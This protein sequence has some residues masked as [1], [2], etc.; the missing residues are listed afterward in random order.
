MS[1][2]FLLATFSFPGLIITEKEQ[3][4]PF[5]EGWGRGIYN[6]MHRILMGIGTGISRRNFPLIERLI[7]SFPLSEACQ[8]CYDAGPHSARTPWRDAAMCSKRGRAVWILHE[9]QLFVA[10]LMAVHGGHSDGPG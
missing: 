6:S 10:G 9:Q 2:S 1:G 7:G 4:D 5:R 3:I 8:L